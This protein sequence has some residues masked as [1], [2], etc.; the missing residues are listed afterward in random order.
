MNCCNSSLSP[1]AGLGPLQSS[2][3]RSNQNESKIEIRKCKPSGISLTSTTLQTYILVAGC[4]APC[5]RLVCLSLRS[6]SWYPPLSS[7]GSSCAGPL[8]SHG[9]HTSLSTVR[10]TSHGLPHLL[11]LQILVGFLFT[12][13][14]SV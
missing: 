2:I 1:G 3:Y 10:S 11:S 13:Q 4:K 5:D 6:H 9:L 12:F 8:Q 7:P 14:V